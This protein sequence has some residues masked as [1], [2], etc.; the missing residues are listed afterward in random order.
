M[1]RTKS[2]L[3]Q[4]QPARGVET[5]HIFILQRT[6]SAVNA[7]RGHYSALCCTQTSVMS[8]N[9]ADALD[10]EFLDHLTPSTIGVGS[11]G[12]QVSRVL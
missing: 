2:M 7:E 10:V 8:E 12:D 5:N 1:E 3:L 6:Q 9:T 4:R 11:R